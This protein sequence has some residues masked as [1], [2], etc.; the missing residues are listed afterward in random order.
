MVPWPNSARNCSKVL[1]AVVARRSWKRVKIGPGHTAFTRIPSPAWSNAIARV[2]PAT[3][4]LVV[5][6]CTMLPPATTERIEATLTMLPPPVWRI[7]G[8]AAFA[9]KA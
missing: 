5:S 4:A 3:A 8:I 2:R 6:Y 1:P 9:Q 7:R